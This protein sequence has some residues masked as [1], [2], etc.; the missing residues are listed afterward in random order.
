ML[1]RYARFTYFQTS[2]LGMVQTSLYNGPIYFDT[3]PDITLALSDVNIVKALTLN[4]LTSGYNML[5]GSQPLVIIYRIYYKLL[6]TNLNPQA[7]IKNS[8]NSTLLIQS[9]TRDA[10][11]RIPRMMKWSEISL[12]SEWLIENV[13]QPAKISSDDTNL[14]YIQ[15][16]LNRSVKISFADLNLSRVEKPLSINEGINSFAVN[17]IINS[18]ADLT[19]TEGFQ[20]RDKDIETFL[21]DSSSSDFKLKE[22]S[23]NSQ[24]CS[25]FYSTKLMAAPSQASR[26]EEEEISPPASISPSAFDLNAPMPEPVFHHCNAI[27][28]APK[29]MDFHDLD[30]PS[31]EKDFHSKENQQNRFIFAKSFSKHERGLIKLQ[32]VEKMIE[33]QN[34]TLFFDFLHNIKPSILNVVKKSFVLAKNN[35]VVKASHPPLETIRVKGKDDTVVI[36][37]NFKI[38][39]NDTTHFETRKIIEQNNFVNQSLHIIGQQLD[40]IKEKVDS[41]KTIEKPISLAV[42]KDIGKPLIYLPE[43]RKGDSLKTNSQKNLEKIEE[44]LLETSLR[45]VARETT[46]VPEASS[47][48][49]NNACIINHGKDKNVLEH[50]ANE[51]DGSNESN[52]FTDDDI[53][54][55]EDNFGKINVS[56]KLQRI[57]KTKLVNLT[58]NWY[59]KH[60]PPD[61]Q[62]EERVFQNQ[63][64]VSVDK[65]YEWNIDVL[66]EHE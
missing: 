8:G 6:K 66:S 39:K 19:T 2:I 18:F 13:S 30:W 60:T 43:E 44:M 65:L 35:I 27:T 51:S 17:Q 7:V 33:E 59:N 57:L 37:S 38:I 48:T 56:P 41:T 54:V 40:R 31:L 34:N 36:A 45:K 63:F 22:I 49:V 55:L 21:A 61:L 9:S 29:K 23:T 10:N 14:N 16:Y 1:L 32:W 64:S 26:Y 53:K 50:S 5:E 25:A 52:L 12:P 42:N 46:S 58:K 28:A 4:V 11:I 3:F 20:R 24:V 15:Q 62:F 47:S